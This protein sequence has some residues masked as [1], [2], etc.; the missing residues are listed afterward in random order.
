[1]SFEDGARLEIMTKPDT[2]DL[3]KEANRTG[4]AHFAMSLG[5]SML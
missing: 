1:M 3:E 5:Q 4:L 2:V